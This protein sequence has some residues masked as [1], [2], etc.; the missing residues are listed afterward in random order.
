MTIYQIALIIFMV[1]CL[2]QGFAATSRGTLFT[3]KVKTAVAGVAVFALVFFIIS[4]IISKSLVLA[5]AA[6]V[7]YLLFPGTGQTIALLMM[8]RVKQIGVLSWIVTAL[9]IAAAYCVIF[10]RIVVYS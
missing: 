3:E 8:G 5:I 4:A 10:G 9:A 6:I 2:A 7:F 1:I